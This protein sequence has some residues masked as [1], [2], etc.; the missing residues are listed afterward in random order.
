MITII[1]A[2]VVGLL[3]TAL[4]FQHA[5]NTYDN[6]TGTAAGVAGFFLAIGTGVAAV[7]YAFTVYSWMASEHKA[8]IINR[9]FGTHYTQQDVF[10]ASDVIDEIRELQRKRIELNGDLMREPKEAAE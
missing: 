7:T 10:W 6:W 4:L 1:I 2:I 9:E 8:R 5:S 3:V